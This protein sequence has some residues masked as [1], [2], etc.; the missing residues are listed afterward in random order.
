MSSDMN[1]HANVV[2]INLGKCLYYAR[3]ERFGLQSVAWEG[4]DIADRHAYTERANE[5][6]ETLRPAPSADFAEN[7][8]QMA[9]SM[10]RAVATGLHRPDK[11]I[12]AIAPGG[13]DVN[14]NR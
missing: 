5:L 8:F 1:L 14:G 9:V 2:A 12:G 6:L 13:F 3:C 7:L 11:I 4:L 10:N